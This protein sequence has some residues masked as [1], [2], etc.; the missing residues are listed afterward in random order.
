MVIGIY[1]LTRGGIMKPVIKWSGSKRS[2]AKHI[3]KNIPKNIKSYKEPFIGGGSVLGAIL[4]SEDHNPKIIEVSDLNKDLINLWKDIKNSPKEVYKHYRQLWSMLNSLE[5]IQD[6]KDFYNT[7]RDRLNKH[8]DPKDFMFIMRTCVNGMPR[9]NSKGDFN[10][11]LHLNRGGIN[12]ETLNKILM[13][14]SYELNKADVV[15]EHKSY[16]EVSV[17]KEDFLY[18]DPP[19]ANTKGMYFDNFEVT[20]L[21]SWLEKVNCS[22]LLSFDGKSG[23]TDNTWNVPENLYDEHLYIDS[24]NSSFKRLKCENK[25]Q[26]VQES[27]YLKY[28]Y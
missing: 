16:N 15:F 12:P 18:L 9:Y 1:V 24:G 21:F 28:K 19:Y 17:E 27:L 14:W 11:S 26:N 22:Y 5:H 10:T 2:Q 13:E 25:Y 20:Q 6:K 4:K 7:I 8:H 23:E 3:L